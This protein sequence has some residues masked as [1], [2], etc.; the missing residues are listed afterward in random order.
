MV[1]NLRYLLPVIHLLTHIF[2][3]LRH[4]PVRLCVVLRCAWCCLPRPQAAQ[5]REL[6]AAKKEKVKI[7]RGVATVR[8]I[9][10]E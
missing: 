8:G 3:K 10:T 2:A 9:Q 5:R 1:A 7:V 4:A 6:E